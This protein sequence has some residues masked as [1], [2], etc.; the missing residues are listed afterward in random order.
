MNV[1]SEQHWQTLCCEGAVE[2]LDLGIAGV[3]VGGGD[4]LHV[5]Y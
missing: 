5:Y 1:L 2:F 4:I 3:T